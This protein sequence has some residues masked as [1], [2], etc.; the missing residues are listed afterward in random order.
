MDYVFNFDRCVEHFLYH[1]LQIY[2]NID[3]NKAADLVN[4]IKIYH[5]Y[6]V[7]GHLPWQKKQESVEFSAD[8][9]PRQLLSLAT[10]I[11]TF[12]EGTD[13]ASSQILAIRQSLK[14]A[15]IFIFLGFAFHHLNLKLLTPTDIANQPEHYYGYFATA[16]GISASNCK[17]IENDLIKMK[18][19]VAMRKNLRPDL[20]CAGLFGEYWR[21]L[22][23]SE[24]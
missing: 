14:E 8:P 9:V 20:K 13:T 23:L 21:S 7:V 6:G 3:E 11:K 15:S 12:T 22:S 19:A 24:Y 4:S 1:S 16:H 18:G 2:Y 10:Q 17:I 5:P